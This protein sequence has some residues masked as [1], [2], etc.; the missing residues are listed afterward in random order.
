MNYIITLWED[1]NKKE[2]HKLSLSYGDPGFYRACTSLSAFS[3]RE[4]TRLYNCHKIKKKMHVEG[5][6]C[7]VQMEGEIIDISHLAQYGI[8]PEVLPTFEHATV[9]DFYKAVGYDYKRKKY[10][11]GS[12]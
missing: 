5:K 2:T 11:C 12:N 6:R 1:G 9:W 8:Y 7:H 3:S 4:G 10:V